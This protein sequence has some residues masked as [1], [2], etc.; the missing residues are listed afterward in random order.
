[1]DELDEVVDKDEGED[2][3]LGVGGAGHGCDL[4]S[5]FIIPLKI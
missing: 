1:L 5:N 2:D 3:P 4:A